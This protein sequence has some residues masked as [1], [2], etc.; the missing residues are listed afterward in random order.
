MK[1]MR[2]PRTRFWLALIVGVML[3]FLGTTINN[4]AS[5]SNTGDHYLC[6]GKQMTNAQIAEYR[7][8]SLETLQLLNVKRGLTIPEI[9]EMPQSKLDRAIFKAKNPNPDHPG[10]AVEFRKLQLQDENGYIPADGLVVAHEQMKAMLMQDAGVNNV[11]GISRGSWTWL[12]PG[13]IGGRVR[14]IVIHPTTTTTM[15]AGSVSG[16]IW[17]TTN[18]G[19]SWQS[20]DDFMANMA[21][22]TLVMDPS[23]PNT[24]YAGTGEGFYN[25]DGLRGAGVF[26][27]T[28]I[29][30][31]HFGLVLR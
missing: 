10:E 18:G 29:R 31:Q 26:K 28:V 1:K 2:F 15:W 16:G 19:V 24:L 11:G 25:A 17:K 21:V 30:D 5:T 4:N 7:D 3:V 23:D 14:A 12:G 9:C 20:L 13:N 8:I 27:T 6:N 22:S